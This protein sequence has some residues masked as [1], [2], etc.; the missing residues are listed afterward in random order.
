M[1]PQSLHEVINQFQ[2]HPNKK[3]GQHF[4]TDNYLLEQIVRTAHM[5]DGAHI[6]EVGPGPGGLTR[7]IL[8]DARTASLHVIELDSRCIA[9]LTPLQPHHPRLHIIKGDALK[10]DM[11]ALCPAPRAI[12]A[13]LPYNVGTTM[14]IEWLKLIHAH[15]ADAFAS[16]TVMLQK[17]VIERICATPDSKSYGKLSLLC[18]WLCHTDLCFDV[19]PEHFTPPPK[20]M[21]AIVRL[22]PKDT[23]VFDASFDSV[24][25]FLNCA[26]S[27]RR[28]MLRSS[29][30]GYTENPTA[31]LENCNIDPTLR[32][33]NLKLRDIAKIL[34]L[35]NK[36]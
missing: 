9:A 7:A 33:E 22:S 20:V 29:L 4:L 14:L 2:L 36:R 34:A 12:I 6:I 27:Q 17:E 24:M 28:K 16:I 25:H 13:N 31:L 3:L 1:H 18:Q 19:P 21:S 30:K 15:G 11:L 35:Q 23:R 10:Q 26:F 32:A 5:P 8:N